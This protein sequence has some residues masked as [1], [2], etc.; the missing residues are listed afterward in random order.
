MLFDR[1]D[2][3]QC[4]LFIFAILA[5]AG[6]GGMAPAASMLD[7][8]GR[9]A[10]QW[11]TE[12]DGLPAAAL[13]G[14]A[15]AVDGSIVC[16]TSDRIVRFD[17]V[18]FAPIASAV[19]DEIHDRIGDFWSIGVDG[20][21]HI[22]VQGRNA[23]ARLI[24]SDDATGRR[25]RWTVHVLPQGRLTGMSFGRNES[26]VFFGSG[27]LCGCDGRRVGGLF[28]DSGKAHAWLYG[29]VDRTRDEMWLWGEGPKRRLFRCRGPLDPRRPP[30][31]EEDTSGIAS[32]LITMGFGPSGAFALLNDCVAVFRDGRWER[33]PPQLPDPDY[34]TSGKLIES[35]DGTLW[36]SS[37]NGLLACR[38]GLIEAA[39]EN[40]PGFSYFT[41]QLVADPSGGVWAACSGG[42][43][44]VRRTSLHVES[45]DDCRAVYERD[46]G[47]L[48]V[49]TPG[50]IRLH[51]ASQTTGAA[52]AAPLQ[53]QLVA[54]LPKGAIPTAIVEDK[55]RRIWVGTQANF[56]LRI[57]DGVVTQVT[58]PAVHDK[59]LRA[60][61]ALAQGADDR[62]WAGT[63]NGV[64]V[65][66]PD[67]DTFRTVL[68][69]DQPLLSVVIGL[70]ADSDGSML[71]ATL[72]RGV[73]RVTADGRLSTV[74]GAGDM[75][76]RRGIV[77]H[78]DSR[79]TL[80]IGGDRGLVRL[81]TDGKPLRL[82]SA[83]GLVD[84]AVRQIDEDSTG[85][86]WI[87]TRDGR[88]QGVMLESLAD[89]AAGR[90]ML[91]RG[92]VLGD[93]DGLG[94]NECIGHFT[95]AGAGSVARRTITVPLSH[96]I[97]RLDAAAFA[98]G[99]ARA[100][101]PVVSRDRAVAVG[102][103]HAV[104]G[105]H[106]TGPPLQQTLLRGVDAAWS[107]PSAAT[108]STYDAP[109]PGEHVFEVRTVSGETDRDFPVASLAATV[110]APWWQ[111]PWMLGAAGL[112]IAAGGALAAREAT[113]RR[114]RR[115]I[116]HLERQQDMDRE[117]ARIARDIHDSL[118]AGLTRVAL[119]SDLA[120]RG[121][122]PSGPMHDR[123]QAIYSSAKSL[124]RSVDEIVWAVNPKNDTVSRF[125][126]YVVNDVEDFVRAG[127]LSLRVDVPE[128]E[129]DRPLATQ[130]R[131]HVCLAVREILQNVLRHAQA[132]HVDFSIQVTTHELT[133]TI[134]DDGIGFH[135]DQALAADQDGLENIRNR[136]AE[137]EGRVEFS[138]TPR[139]GTRVT[140]TVAID[141]KTILRPGRHTPPPVPPRPAPMLAQVLQERTRHAP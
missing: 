57:E 139:S 82:T 31:V 71:A 96:G 138:S 64:A 79:G 131:H 135:R 89:V 122:Q 99:A 102:F 95:R 103:R 10:I 75:P 127:E 70:A 107:P 17:G 36:I 114:A 97:V 117:R 58:K 60:I 106:W 65:H 21:G 111:S 63:S 53:P 19:T 52:S 38:D 110:P 30:T 116:A 15:L 76:G 50:A 85:R 3:V 77:F 24:E 126:S 124:A 34:R 49:G 27:V 56:I 13:T 134:Q 43:L 39:I 16:A 11:W 2:G 61:Q 55:A 112:G 123:L 18:S 120:R 88:L 46:D 74:L 69:R 113:R 37:H 8:T 47:A 90:A 87:A 80:W 59:E 105:I 45:V 132:S 20:D 54:T 72:S 44:A 51:P 12:D 9:F 66:D 137:V 42:L 22:W 26:P 94:D 93:L 7:R 119:M 121:G 62:I 32:S 40:L 98:A 4:R 141:P 14:V 33:L 130:V 84:D 83:T 78:R 128:D 23:A 25:A 109:P 86:L 125:V 48:L 1:Y 100:P 115:R 35:V 118:G 73:E 92:V 104:P 29:G 6:S 41:N 101:A 67:S 91:V 81:A 68:E 129:D 133:V 108:R 136:V 28:G 140:L 5:C